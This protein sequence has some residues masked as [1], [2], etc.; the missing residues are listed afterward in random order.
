VRTRNNNSLAW[1]RAHDLITDHR[2][3]TAVPTVAAVTANSPAL[4]FVGPDR[5]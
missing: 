2:P 5:H 1:V 4:F 3:L